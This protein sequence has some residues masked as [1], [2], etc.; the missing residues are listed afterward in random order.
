MLLYG[1]KINTQSDNVF[2]KQQK[3]VSVQHKRTLRLL[4][5]VIHDNVVGVCHAVNDHFHRIFIVTYLLRLVNPV[6]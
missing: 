4:N 1:F 6:Y 3:K 2:E 5:T